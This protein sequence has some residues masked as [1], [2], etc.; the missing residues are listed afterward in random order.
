MTN[1]EGGRHGVHTPPL[2]L[3]DWVG[4]PMQSLAI[5]GRPVNPDLVKVPF[6]WISET[7]ERAPSYRIV[8]R[9][10]LEEQS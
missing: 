10:E 6:T 4:L 3:G 1:A 5:E 8:S 2:E 7:D 9:A